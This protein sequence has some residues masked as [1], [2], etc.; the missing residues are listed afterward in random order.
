MNQVYRGGVAPTALHCHRQRD[1]AQ[2]MDRVQLLPDATGEGQSWNRAPLHKQ[3]LLAAVFLAAFLLL[4]GASSASQA[5][6]GAPACYLPV[7]L[8]LAVLLCGGLRYVPL[9]FISSL[10]AA[11]VN[12][13]RPLYSW[14]GIPGSTTIYFAYIAGAAILRGPWRIDSRLGTLRDVGR[15][16]LIFLGAAIVS[17]PLGMLTLLGDD[18]VHRS[19]ALKTTLDWLASDAVSIVTFAPF[20]LL[21]VAPRVSRWLSPVAGIPLPAEVRRPTSLLQM[22]EMAGQAGI[23]LVAVWLVFGWAAAMPYQPLYLFF[24]PV[25]WLAVRHGLP[26]A[27]LATFAINVGMTFAAW[28]VQAPSGS[29]PRLQLAIL[30]LGLTGLCLGAVVSERRRS[31][32]ALQSKTALLEAQANSTIDGILVVD[33][34]DQRLMHNQRL[35]ELFSVPAEILADSGDW[36]L[37]SHVLTLLKEPE[38][39]PGQGALPQQ[40]SRRDQP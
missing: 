25:V 40:P 3:L 9:I 34:R 14:A 32:S 22:L 13:H 35:V 11:V 27:T 29:L 4:D 23:I 17:A 12:Y 21:H 6:E 37:L 33:E 2:I 10:V 15:F 8:T 16:V 5:W 28:F 31:E 7:G 20:L 19:D 36:P 1:C 38:S 18:I 26:G 39:L 24:V 30:A